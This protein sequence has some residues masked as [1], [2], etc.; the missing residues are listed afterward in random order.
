MELSVGPQEWWQ[1]GLTRAEATLLVFCFHGSR[2]HHLS[3]LFH[4]TVT[5]MITC[6]SVTNVLFTVC[7]FWKVKC[8]T[9][10]LPL[11]GGSMSVFTGSS[12]PDAG[13]PSVTWRGIMLIT[14][15]YTT[16]VWKRGE[17]L[18]WEGG[19]KKGERSIKVTV[20][21]D[22]V[23]G[24]D[25]E[26]K[27]QSGMRPNVRRILEKRWWEWK[28]GIKYRNTTHLGEISTSLLT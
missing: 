6:P 16:G 22:A 10:V 11:Y 5:S 19:R 26:M 3:H 7:I 28:E 27:T 2:K 8:V 15:C 13:T 20:G 23:K 14:D 21:R 9:S 17:R 4:F 12:V 25:G 18:R 24:R 1:V